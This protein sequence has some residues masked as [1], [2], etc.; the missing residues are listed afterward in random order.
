[1][2]KAKTFVK[3]TKRGNIIKVVR[4]HYLRDDLSCGSLLC[5][6]C[7]H[8]SPAKLS[9]LQKAESSLFPKAHYLVIDTNVALHQIDFLEDHNITD[10]IV[11]QTVLQEVKHLNDSLYKRIRTV[12]ENN[13]K[14]FFVLC[15]EHH[16]AT[17]I[18]REPNES[19][20]DRNDRAIRVATS[21]Y[22]EHLKHLDIDIVL[23]TN[24]NENRDKAIKA[25]LKSYQVMDYVKSLK[26]CENLIDHLS[27]QEKGDKTSTVHDKK[28]MFDEHL[29]L[30]DI[31]MG[32][33]S[34][35][36]HQG[37]FEASRENY[38]EGFVS[39]TAYDKQVI[40]RGLKNLN[41]AVHEDVV[42]IEVFPKSQWVGSSGTV[43]L[44]EKMDEE[45]DLNTMPDAESSIYVRPTGRIIGI[46]KRNWRNYCGVLLPTVNTEKTRHIF[47]PS[48]KRIP[49]IRIETRQA[50]VLMSHRIIVSVDCWPRSSRY[51]LGHFIRDIGPMGDRDTEEEVLLLEHDVP[52]LPFSKSVLNGL[53]KLPWTIPDYEFVLREDL[54]N[55]SVC[56]VDPP[57][58][59][60]IDDAL[61][62]KPLPNGNCQVGVHIA[63]LSYFVR[64]G[65]ALDLE[66]QKRGTSVY[67]CDKRIDMVPEVLS[68]NLCS[69]RANEDRLSF[70]GIWEMTKEG[71]IVSRRFCKTVIRSVAA[72]TYAE[73][74]IL[75]DDKSRTDALSVG[76]RG[77]NELAKKLKKRRIEA[78]ALTLASPE[79]RFHIDSETHDPIGIE[80]KELKET[81]SMIEEFMLLANCEVAR[82]IEKE[83]PQCA[84]LR[85]HPAPPLTNFDLLVNAAAVKG[86]QVKCSTNA[87]LAYSLENANIPGDPFFNILLRIVST[88]CMMQAVYFCSGMLPEDEYF[89]Y[90]LAVPMYT[91]FTSPIRRYPDLLVHRLLA[92]SVGQDKTYTELL[93]RNIVH[94]WC[95]NMNYRHHQAQLVQR[96]SIALHTQLYFKDKCLDE[97]AYILFVRRNAVVVLVRR[98]GLESTIF[99]KAIESEVD[100]VYE[101]DKCKLTIGRVTLQM[102]DRVIV[103]ISVEDCNIQHKK[104]R[105]KLV[106]PIIP[107]VSVEPI[108]ITM[109]NNDEPH[110]PRPDTARH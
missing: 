70:S 109:G 35:R 78:G 100:F 36:Y 59:T 31:K 75:I 48:E 69:L 57:G 44:D 58:C 29:S 87:E 104:L 90:G 82:H 64:P 56:S 6:K 85:R 94:E 42:A 103:Q 71:E 79:V 34:N 11:L 2:L 77:L 80:T 50:D 92:A 28:V 3:K 21:W 9:E 68:S 84:V 19:C 86:I 89:H 13:S 108:Y 53:P 55:T 93:D 10:V 51:P 49:R 73:A 15:N 30:Y 40:V 98:Y 99:L 107:G 5:D 52:H 67:L 27:V 60:D 74:Q 16:R 110:V 63:D 24:D 17:Y 65:T 61:H 76:L 32:V 95:E 46:I 41:R 8:L 26:G 45:E 96:A 25:G 22:E 23:L 81:N 14:R 101:E 20:N 18:D 39:C 7:P 33:K 66:A 47:I 38:L 91:H 105:M 72:L 12:I 106:N 62:Y 37:K 54:R 97:D 83:F 4:E 88:R 102:F 1:M 43:R